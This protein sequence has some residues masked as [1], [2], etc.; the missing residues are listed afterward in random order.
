MSFT[1]KF[2]TWLLLIIYQWRWLWSDVCSKWQLT[3]W[4]GTLC[5]M[6]CTH[7]DNYFSYV[8]LNVIHNCL[9]NVILCSFY[10][11]MKHFLNSFTSESVHSHLFSSIMIVDILIIFVKVWLIIYDVIS[12]P[13]YWI[14]QRPY[15]KE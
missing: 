11:L 5:V 3:S 10:S 13:I 2:Y 12:F 6:Y 7:G 4:A 14:I 9:N 1:H 8:T 15:R